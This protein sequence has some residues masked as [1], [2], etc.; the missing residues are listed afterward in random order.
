[1]VSPLK[2]K[3]LL[4]PPYGELAASMPDP[5]GFREEPKPKKW[6][7]GGTARREQQRAGAGPTPRGAAGTVRAGEGSA[8]TITGPQAEAAGA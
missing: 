3:G 2:R 4:P 7:R 5:K 6:T 8:D 1:M